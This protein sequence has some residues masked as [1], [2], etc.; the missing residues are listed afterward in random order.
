MK[1]FRIAIDNNNELWILSQD[2]DLFK[3][4]TN[5][6]ITAY[7]KTTA[8]DVL[9]GIDQG[10]VISPVLW[11]IYYD[12]LLAEINKQNLGYT[13]SCNNIQQ[14]P[15]LNSAV[16]EQHVPALAFMDDTQWITDKKDKLESML[17]IADSFYRL[18][19]IQI[20]KEK[21]ELMM[22]TKM[23]K[24]RYSHIYNNKINIQFGRESISIKAKHP[25]EPTRILG[26]YFNIENDEQFLISKVKAEIDH[27]T[28]LMWKKKIT[29]KH[30]LY[31]FNRIII[32]RVEYWSQVFV[33]SPDLIHR[34]FVPFRRMF[35]N[36]LKFARTAP[37]AI[38][39]NSY[40]YG[41]RN[42]YENQLQA[43][44]TNFCIQ[45]NDT[46]ILGRI[47]EIRL[48][49]LQQLL[50]CSRP[51]IEGIPFDKI[52]RRM[53]NNYLLNMIN[54]MRQ[55]D[56]TLL[57]ID[58]GRFP[59]IAGG[60]NDFT[61]VAT[62]DFLSKYS[63]ILRSRQI[64]FVEQIISG[65]KRRLLNWTDIC[66]KHYFQSIPGRGNKEEKWYMDIQKLIT[67]DGLN[68]KPQIYNKFT[69]FFDNIEETK[70]YDIEKQDK[71]L[72]VVYSP[73]HNSI[74]FGK[75]Q[76]FIDENNILLRH[77]HADMS[78]S[79]STST[80]V[81]ICD[82]TL[83][84]ANTVN[85][86]S[87][88]VCAFTANPKHIVPLLSAAKFTKE[89]VKR[90]KMINFNIFNLFDQAKKKYVLSQSTLTRNHVIRQNN[91]ILELLEP[92]LS[93][94]ELLIIQRKFAIFDNPNCCIF[95]FFTD[96]SLIELGTEQ[97]NISCAF[98]HLDRS[99]GI[100]Q[101]EFYTTID[102]WPSAYRGE[103]LA[104]I[105]ALMVVPYRSKVR[106]NI[107]SLNVITMF[108]GFKCN[109]FSL[110]S[111]D[112]F[113]LNNSYLW[114]ILIRIIR[115]QNLHVEMFKVAAHTDCDGNNYVDRLAK[116]AHIDQDRFINFIDTA[117]DIKVLPLW[118]NI[119]IETHLRKFIKMVSH[120]KGL[121]KFIN[122][123]R[124][125]KYRKLEVDW[126]STFECLNCDIANNE[127]SMSSSKVKAHKV[128][129]L[130]EEIPT[131]EQMKK[132]FLELYDGWKCPSCGL[133]DETFDHVWTCDEHR[134]LLLKIK[135]NTIDLLLSLL[136]E[137]NP[138]IT[139]YSA[140]LTLNIWT[141]STDP[142]NFTFVDLIKGF[143][144]L[145]LTQI[146][147]LWIPRK[148]LLLVI[149]EI[150][151]YIYEQTF[152]EIWIRRC[153]FIKE[154]ERSLGITKKKKLTLKNFRPFNNI[155]NSDRELEYKFDALD[156]IRNNIYF[157]KAKKYIAAANKTVRFAA[158]SSLEVAIKQTKKKV[159]MIAKECHATNRKFRDREFDLYSLAK[160]HGDYEHI[161]RG[162]TGQ[163]IE[164]L[165]GG[166]YTLTYTADILDT[167]RFWNEEL[168]H[169][170]KNVLFDCYRWDDSI[171]PKGLLD[172]HAY[173][174]LRV[175][176]CEDFLKQ[177]T[178]VDKCK[179]FNASL[180]VYSTWIHYNVV[181]K[182][183]G[184]F[185]LAIPEDSFTIIVLQQ[186]DERFFSSTSKYSYQLS[187]HIYHIYEQGCETYKARSRCAVRLAPRSV[188]LEVKLPA[189]TYEI[190]PNIKHN[191]VENGKTEGEEENK[192][193]KEKKLN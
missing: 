3:D 110:T 123:H 67:V 53:K 167:E 55:N 43:K 62:F 41:Y 99:F 186:P 26:V 158:T 23:Y 112:Y 84:A 95:E 102:K 44:I 33:L 79:T 125:T 11:C 169:V 132:S 136:F 146:L 114:S 155:L 83:C 29:D 66:N 129:L 122:L 151:Q 6:V 180:Q 141:I 72:S 105:L 36:K 28:N 78:Q 90:R 177:W 19:D 76:R 51:L 119:I 159:E 88:G 58:K 60:K 15:Q 175:E 32:P 157:D 108:E 116:S 65:D 145:E 16:I 100:P 9:T 35:K 174:I 134:S 115:Q 172:G 173:S 21:S 152:K 46:G 138:D 49:L 188:N 22:R 182:S 85:R 1:S 147:N 149:I 160:V 64:M 38:L 82:D 94:N 45:L 140:L 103:L 156:S 42:P 91:I 143:I 18:N 144:P 126:T 178:V 39:D 190:V 181:P 163:G 154:F 87:M 183:N 135:N 80:H 4:R 47:T 176:E 69:T 7:G 93:R 50:W 14:V 104:V 107:D 117:P 13:V 81:T 166:V 59:T 30:I 77:Y 171:D 192:K 37:N 179:L 71:S 187:I 68:I 57:V 130:I 128:H 124:N 12:P 168:I 127:T 106:I 10:E 133:E 96:G 17:S 185:I 137:Y 101:V 170:N 73:Q 40:I 20:N 148:Q 97:C 193:E 86:S 118:N 131:I 63:T 5:Q 161:A 34:L 75:V 153:S 31:I 120:I 52:P 139:D 2:M 74:L 27:L 89:D 189:G 56:F 25:H 8:Y 121:E 61:S 113:K 109:N 191:N 184:K 98:A 150:R 24:R 92:G 70:S 165:T 164:D 162:F 54:L 48:K 111:R 142:D